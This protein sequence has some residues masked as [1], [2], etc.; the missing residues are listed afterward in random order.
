MNL[1][2]NDRKLQEYISKFGNKY[3]AIQQIMKDA[4]D[5]SND[6]EVQISDSQA[7]S[8]IVSGK[9]NLDTS[10]KTK[11][12]KNISYLDK[13]ISARLEGVSNSY[14]CE[15]VR[16]SIESSTIN[17]NLSYI[18]KGKLNESEKV[19]IRILTRMIWSDMK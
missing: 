18:Y 16:L 9:H 11:V 1:R 12:S 13:L 15:S 3:I 14:I 19:R 6:S 5:L 4:R 10:A 8:Q 17:S 2:E 7:L